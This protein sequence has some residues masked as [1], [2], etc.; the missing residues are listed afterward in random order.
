[1]KSGTKIILG[2][3]I[4]IIVFPLLLSLGSSNSQNSKLSAPPDY[5]VF[6]KSMPYV[7]DGNMCIGRHVVVSKDSTDKEL[8]NIL[9]DMEK[10]DRNEYA[11]YTIWFYEAKTS[12]D[13]FAILDTEEVP[14]IS[15]N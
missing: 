11:E 9:T 12:I 4:A 3:F 1:M 14:N 10:K 15:R 7:R 13:Y 5:E 8:E 2:F 6:G